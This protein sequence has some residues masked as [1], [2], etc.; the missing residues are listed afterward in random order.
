MPFLRVK[1]CRLHGHLAEHRLLASMIPFARASLA[2]RKRL[3]QVKGHG[4]TSVAESVNC[5]FRDVA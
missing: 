2:F 5:F 3:H 1:D 4:I